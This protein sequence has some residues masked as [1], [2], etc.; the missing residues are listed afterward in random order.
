MFGLPHAQAVRSVP[1]L[2]CSRLDLMKPSAIL[3]NVSRG[4]LIDTN[5]L[6]VALEGNQLHG[7]AMDV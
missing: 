1:L 2:C 4:G 5:D 3:I 7:V 6:I